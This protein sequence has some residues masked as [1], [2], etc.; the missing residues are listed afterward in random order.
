[1]ANQNLTRADYQALI[2]D[3]PQPVKEKKKKKKRKKSDKIIEDNVHLINMIMNNPNKQQQTAMINTMNKSQIKGLQKYLAQFLE[4][5]IQLPPSTLKKLKKDKE[6]IY[7]LL[8]DKIPIKR[9]KEILIQKG[10]SI[11]SLAKLGYQT[12]QR[13]N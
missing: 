6:F 13:N 5:R 1:M 12:L 7:Q 10:G 4:G 2:D 9:K 3:D 11:K 8:N